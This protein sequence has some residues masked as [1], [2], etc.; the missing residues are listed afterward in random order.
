M[1][2]SLIISIFRTLLRESVS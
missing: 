1:S 2:E